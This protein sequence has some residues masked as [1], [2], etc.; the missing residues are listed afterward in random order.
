MNQKLNAQNDWPSLAKRANWS[1][2]TLADLV[3]VSLRT[4]ERYFI[5]NMGVSPKSWMSHQRQKQAVGLLQ[6]GN[7]VKEVAYYVGY[8]NAS[9]FSREFKK[10]WGCG[11]MARRREVAIQSNES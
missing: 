8:Q 4:L 7:T 11:P 3:G 5:I 1:A 6:N 9:A 10:Y 2:K